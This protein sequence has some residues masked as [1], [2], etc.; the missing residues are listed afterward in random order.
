MAKEKNNEKKTDKAFIIIISVVVAIAL[1]VVLSIVLYDPVVALIELND[2]KKFN[3]NEDIVSAVYTDPMKSS[4]QAFSN[5]EVVFTGDDADATSEYLK[6]LMK[7]VKY[8]GV[9]KKDLGEWKHRITLYNDTDERVIYLGESSIYLRKG[10]IL[11]EYS[12]K[13]TELDDYNK[14]ISELSE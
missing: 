2:V 12:I 11:I 3:T 14:F 10:G 7:N 4:G 6:T 13:T 5:Y 9:S 8:K 1:S